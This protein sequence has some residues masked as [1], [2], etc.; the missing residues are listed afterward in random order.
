MDKKFINLPNT[1]KQLLNEIPNLLN[2]DDIEQLISNK[3]S[4]D[5][6]NQLHKNINDKMKEL[7]CN[8]YDLN[9]LIHSYNKKNNKISFLKKIANLRNKHIVYNCSKS[10]LWK[11]NLRTLQK[12]LQPIFKKK[13][14]K[15]LI[16]ESFFYLMKKYKY[17]WGGLWSIMDY[18]KNGIVNSINIFDVDDFDIIVSYIGD[19]TDW[20]LKDD[21]YLRLKKK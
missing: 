19:K 8:Q 18:N 6:L 13:I 10:N 12:K 9:K 7:D 21:S 4:F 3:I 11:D 1:Y 14:S 20:N 5:R 2:K 15:K 17:D 16:E